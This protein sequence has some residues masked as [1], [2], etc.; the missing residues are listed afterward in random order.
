LSIKLII[1]SI[2]VE[3]AKKKLFEAEE[4]IFEMQEANLSVIALEQLLNQSRILLNEKKVFK[5]SWEL[6]DQI[7][8]TRDVASEAND[9]LRRLIEAMKN[10][11]NNNLIASNVIKNSW[12]YQN[13]TPLRDLLTGKAV[14]TSDSLSNLV[15]QAVAAFE[16]GDYYASLATAKEARDLLLSERSAN[17]FLFFYTY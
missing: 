5:K 9:L 2:S 11:K 3:E 7:V 13:E 10:P 1:Q 4:A 17:L 8:K 16:K 12:D 14:L 6:S 15:G